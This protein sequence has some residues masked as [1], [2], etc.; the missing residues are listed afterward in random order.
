MRK[1]EIQKLFANI[2]TLTTD[3]LVLRKVTKADAEDMFEYSRLDKVTEYLRWYSHPDISHTRR[4]LSMVEREYRIG[5][6]YDW[7]IV[8]RATGKLIGTCGFTSLDTNNMCGEI[9]YVISPAYAN[10]G[11]AT[12]AVGRV[13]KFGFE[14]LGLNRIEGRFMAENSASRRVMEKNGMIFE[15]IKRESLL[16]KGKFVSVGICSILRKEWVSRC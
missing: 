9:G 3:R 15:G 2:P 10:L 8:E 11:L 6:F 16:V 7:G 14:V 4:H 12:E 13:L 5:C 1:T